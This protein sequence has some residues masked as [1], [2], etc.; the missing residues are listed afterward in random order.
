MTELLAALVAPSPPP[1]A[2]TLAAWCAATAAIRARWDVPVER[3]L[4]CGVAA[5]RL[6]FAFAGGYA[7]AL[8]AL[9]PG[10]TGIAA[11]GA[12]EAGGRAPQ[13][14]GPPVAGPAQSRPHL[15]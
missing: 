10:L 5:D 7:A 1:A 4:A 13:A 15:R 2:D 14:D 9:V 12:T 11:L 6:G 8:H 3:A